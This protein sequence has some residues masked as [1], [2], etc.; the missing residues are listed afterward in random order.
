MVN[1]PHTHKQNNRNYKLIRDEVVRVPTSN[2]KRHDQSG[3]QLKIYTLY[4]ISLKIRK[5]GKLTE[6]LI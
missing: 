5:N 2:S 4:C 1:L 6:H 3:T